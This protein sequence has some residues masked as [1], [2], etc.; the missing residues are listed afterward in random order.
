MLGRRRVVAAKKGKKTF[1]VAVS[2][3]NFEIV[4]IKKA[5]F[6]VYVFLKIDDK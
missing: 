4:Y 1:F 2:K 3:A 5:L 6:T